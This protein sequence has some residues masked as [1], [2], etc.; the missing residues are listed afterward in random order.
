MCNMTFKEEDFKD[1]FK[2]MDI[3]QHLIQTVIDRI[4]Q[5]GYEYAKDILKVNQAYESETKRIVSGKIVEESV[6]FKLN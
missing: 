3:R 4:N 1:P 5:H 2:L 6:A